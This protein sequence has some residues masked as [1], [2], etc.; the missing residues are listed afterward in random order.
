MDLKKGDLVL[1]KTSLG[2]VFETP[3]EP[4]KDVLQVLGVV[5]EVEEKIDFWMKSHFEVRKTSKKVK[6]RSF[7][8]FLSHF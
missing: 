5:L 2:G 7:L 6:K 8:R 1:P 3:F 4:K